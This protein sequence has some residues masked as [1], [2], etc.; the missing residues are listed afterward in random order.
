[1][2][3]GTGSGTYHGGAGTIYSKDNTAGYEYLL[4][5]GNTRTSN[6]KPTPFQLASH[7]TFEG[8]TLNNN[9]QVKQINTTYN[10][11][12]NT[13][14]IQNSSSVTV[15]TN[16]AAGYGSWFSYSSLVGSPA[17]TEY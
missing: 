14:T 8:V 9:A 11:S 5:D 15:P 1:M 16:S 17:P 12:I 7:S 4:F 6:F 2:Y 3:G 13:L 10:L